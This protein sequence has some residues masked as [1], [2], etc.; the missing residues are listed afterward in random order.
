MSRRTC[1]VDRG[2]L[3][4][5]LA[6]DLAEGVD[7]RI[8]LVGSVGTTLSERLGSFWHAW[9]IKLLCF[10]IGSV[11]SIDAFME[12]LCQLQSDGEREREGDV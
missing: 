1:A 12:S 4:D 6:E 10:C 3:A 2:F 8:R 9:I 7:L 5:R 11:P